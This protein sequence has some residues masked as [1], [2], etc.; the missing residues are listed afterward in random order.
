MIRHAVGKVPRSVAFVASLGWVLYKRGDFNGAYAWLTKAARA[1]LNEWQS[2]LFTEELRRGEDDPV[3]RDHL[4][5][6]AWRLDKK[7]QAVAC[8]R[9]AHELVTA[10][11]DNLLTPEQQAILENQPAKIEAA[12]QGRE[13]EIAPVALENNEKGKRE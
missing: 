4:G 13:P 5:D 10:D 2:W 6:A 7:D 12:L 9:R 1:P 11:A 8:W 3:I